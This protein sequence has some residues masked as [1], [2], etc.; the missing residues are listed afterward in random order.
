[1]KR[2]IHPSDM[3][4]AQIIQCSRDAMVIVALC[5]RVSSDLPSGKQGVIAAR[6]ISVALATAV[7][8]MTCVHD[9]IQAHESVSVAAT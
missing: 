7:E 2:L 4:A 3:T 9:A 1:M 6:D 8:L 5:R